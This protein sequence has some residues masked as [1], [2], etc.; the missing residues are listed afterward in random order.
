MHAM[1]DAGMMRTLVKDVTAAESLLTRAIE[2]WQRVRTPNDELTLR[3]MGQLANLYGAMGEVARAESLFRAARERGLE[4]VPPLLSLG[5]NYSYLLR[6]L[7][8]YADAERV[9]PPL[10]D[11][12]PTA[13]AY[14]RTMVLAELG[15]VSRLRSDLTKSRRYLDESVGGA[16]RAL[17]STSHAMGWLI[18]E[19]G[20]TLVEQQL[21]QKGDSL[22]RQGI[23]V[24][25]TAHGRS[26]AWA[27]EARVALAMSLVRQG[28]HAAARRLLAT[29]L[30]ILTRRRGVPDP[31]V[32]Q[33]RAWLKAPS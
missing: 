14:D 5:Y 4:D 7:G 19:L 1:T 13:S 21:N 29:S 20:R 3:A 8:R 18:S 11:A 9:M 17:E 32:A 2:V 33:A 22:L 27:A 6:S 26:D 10:A 16:P 24:M 30:P 28:R 15:V 31:I 23:A 25:E 12:V